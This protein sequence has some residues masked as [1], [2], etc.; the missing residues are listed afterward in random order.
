MKT[1]IL[2][3]ALILIGS[4]NQADAH[5]PIRHRA[6]HRAP[7]VYHTSFYSGYYAAPAPVYVAPAPV[8]YQTYTV[9]RPVVVAPVIYQPAP[10]VTY[11][12]YPYFW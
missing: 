2:A 1:L 7:V 12:A 5:W 4:I 11:H 3:A 8:V 6:Y 9:A 10:I